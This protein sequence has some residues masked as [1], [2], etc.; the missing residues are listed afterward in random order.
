MQ[1][2]IKIMPKK[3]ETTFQL[4]GPGPP[5]ATPFIGRII[6]AN[7]SWSQTRVRF[8]QLIA[9]LSVILLQ[10]KPTKVKLDVLKTDFQRKKERYEHRINLQL[11]GKILLEFNIS[12]S[13]LYNTT[14]GLW[15]LLKHC[16]K[17]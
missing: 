2:F 11:T 6:K 1:F 3:S 10:L 8:F 13:L 15:W 4:G 17:W 9:S 5:L 14:L 7:L 12:S 16:C